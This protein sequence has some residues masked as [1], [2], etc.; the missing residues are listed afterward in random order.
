MLSKIPIKNKAQMFL[1]ECHKSLEPNLRRNVGF[2]VFACLQIKISYLSK[3]SILA[4]QKTVGF[5]SVEAE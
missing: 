4:K 5:D 2:S 3:E 1:K